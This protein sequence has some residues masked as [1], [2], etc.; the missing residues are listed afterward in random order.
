MVYFIGGS[1]DRLNKDS[2]LPV[3]GFLVP[4]A[5]RGISTIIS[6]LFGTCF[7]GF[8]LTASVGAIII[9]VLEFPG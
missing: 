5:P 6:S 3:A 4:G 7:N 2:K 8:A 9:W 1:T